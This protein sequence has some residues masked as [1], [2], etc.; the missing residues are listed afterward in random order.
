MTVV[1]YYVYFQGMKFGGCGG[2]GVAENKPEQIVSTFKI[3]R[4]WG[5]GS[6]VTITA[7]QVFPRR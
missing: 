7:L 1:E 3:W 5:G 2:L 4:L 6:E